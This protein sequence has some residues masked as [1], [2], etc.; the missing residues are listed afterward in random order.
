MKEKFTLAPSRVLGPEFKSWLSHSSW[1]AP[2]RSLK[3]LCFLLCKR[4]NTNSPIGSWE[5]NT[6]YRDNTQQ[7][8]ST[9]VFN[10][11]ILSDICKYLHS[12]IL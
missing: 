4:A 12:I 11:H 3:Q 10:Q 9:I 6:K 8:S 5:P 7:E 1:E 2:G